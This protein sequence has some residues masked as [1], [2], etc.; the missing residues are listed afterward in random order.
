MLPLRGNLL[1]H[2]ALIV[3]ILSRLR[4]TALILGHI[5]QFVRSKREIRFGPAIPIEYLVRILFSLLDRLQVLLTILIR[6]AKALLSCTLRHLKMLGRQV[7]PTKLINKLQALSLGLWV[8]LRAMVLEI[9]AVLRRDPLVVLRGAKL[10]VVLLEVVLY[11]CLLRVP[12]LSVR[13]FFDPIL[14]IV[15]VHGAVTVGKLEV[16]RFNLLGFGITSLFGDVLSHFFRL[17]IGLRGVIGVLRALSVDLG[18]TWLLT[19]GIGSS[20]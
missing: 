20:C 4:H 10:E 1:V 14:G 15:S 13:L 18:L 6:R 11:D 3:N 9:I 2:R 16:T 8:V 5:V 12:L 19:V 17:L 7:R